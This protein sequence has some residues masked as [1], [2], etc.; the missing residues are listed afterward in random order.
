VAK[1]LDY[2]R[3]GPGSDPINNQDLFLGAL[4]PQNW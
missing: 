1:A 3:R 2:D 4:N